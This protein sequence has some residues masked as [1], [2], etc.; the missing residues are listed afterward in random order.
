MTRRGPSIV[1]AVLLGA[2]A[3]IGSAWAKEALP[4]SHMQSGHVD[5]TP[6]DNAAFYPDVGAEAAPAFS[7]RLALQASA[8]RTLP[9]ID[10]PLQDGRDARIFPGVELEF[11]TLGEQL[12]PVQRGDMVRETAPGATPSFWRVIPQVGRVWHDKAD[13]GWSR[14]AFPVMLVNDTENDAHQGLAM[15]LYRGSQVTPLQFQFVQ[16][17][18]P[19]LLGQHF[20]AWGSAA[21]T[22]ADTTHLQARRA[23]AQRE[24][25]QRLPAKP[26]EELVK[27]VPPGTLDGFGGP[28]NP[29]FL[30]LA[31]LLRDGT[32][33]YQQAMTPYGP[34]PYP[35]EMRF[36]VRSVMKSVGVPLS[37]LH[38]A[39]VYGPWVLTLHIG[40][41]VPGL[42]PKWKRIR[43][44]DA[45]N[46]ASGFGG[47]GTLKTQPNDILDGYLDGNYDAWYTAHSHADKL[48]RI[49]AD[50]RPYPWEPGTVMRYRDQ[51]F[52]VL[53]A[54]LD[55]FLKSVRGPD[56]DIWEMLKAE[57]LAPIGIAQA[58]AVRTREPG[59]ADGL[60]W[61]NAGY[62]P[63]LD[64]LAKIAQLYQA[65]GAHA[66]VQILH[67]QLTTDLLAAR[68][69][70][71]KDGDF[72]V[73]RVLPQNTSG[74]TEFYQMGF[75]FIPYVG[76]ASHR[77]LDLPSM[78]GFGEN[79]VTL[80]P[81]GVVSL[82]FGNAAQFKPGDQIKS[83]QGPRTLQAVDRLTPF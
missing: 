62:Y 61:F 68:G 36:G 9:A 56:A 63:S 31:A 35:L 4:L 34:Y 22:L 70:I 40:D 2:G 46:M 81:T 32:L 20:V 59:D 67:L 39:Q 69:A 83:D 44:I 13:G 23:A 43:F 42:D 11:F 33:Y 51:D 18:A 64:D 80:Y 6:I 10:K 77:R 52:Y 65:R 16:Q 30:V 3:L 29:H 78:N 8:L 58:P 71:Q 49:N 26:W 14:A 7:G 79:E 27:Q 12:V 57:V 73:A 41:Y 15:F 48:A 53:G 17:S 82:I 72:S 74:M 1:A 75:H 76:S 5:S 50:L 45:A 55:A 47:T 37:L 24:L 21:A 60:V 54:A 28:L 38:L 25:A 66:G 19:Y